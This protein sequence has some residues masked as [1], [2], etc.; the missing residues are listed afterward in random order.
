M[1]ANTRRQFEIVPSC[2]WALYSGQKR[3]CIWN[4][5]EG[6]CQWP[7]FIFVRK[8][9]NVSY[10]PQTVSW[11]LSQHTSLTSPSSPPALA[12]TVGTCCWRWGL[13]IFWWRCCSSEPVL[14]CAEPRRLHE[15]RRGLKP[16]GHKQRRLPMKN[17]MFFFLLLFLCCCSFTLFL[18]WMKRSRTSCRTWSKFLSWNL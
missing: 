5:F 7:F 12:G 8:A 9:I 11:S 16:S 1:H 15:P 18:L 6:S 14:L 13:G 10:W 3:G 2:Y 4:V 17:C